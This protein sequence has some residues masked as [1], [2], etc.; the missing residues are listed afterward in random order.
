M[1][2]RP[3]Q[4]AVETASAASRS[5]LCELS[6]VISALFVCSLVSCVRVCTCMNNRSRWQLFI[7][8]WPTMTN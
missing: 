2:S 3:E 6:R 1:P 7:V 4:I 5:Q 8:N